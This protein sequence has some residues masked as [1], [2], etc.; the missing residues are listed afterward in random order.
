M[1]NGPWLSAPGQTPIFGIVGLKQFIPAIQIMIGGYTK[2][3]P[4][5]NKKLPVESEVPELLIDM[6]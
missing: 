5:T 6:G 4:P 3:D 1:S 2:A